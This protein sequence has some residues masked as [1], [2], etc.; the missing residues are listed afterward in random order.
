LGHIIGNLL[1]NAAKYSPS[2]STVLFDLRVQPDQAVFRIQ[3]EGIGIPQAD[4]ARLFEPFH[5]AHNVGTIRGN[6]LGL[7]IVK[8]AVDL[9]SGTIS[10]ESVEGA[11][12]T[13]TVTLPL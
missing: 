1:S 3:D 11:G 5:R 7:A 8:Q 9:H 12:T 6:G 2:G 4:Q 13:F 10:V